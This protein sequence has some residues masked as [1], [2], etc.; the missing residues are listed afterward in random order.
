MAAA[1][2]GFIFV[3]N[4]VAFH[5]GALVLLGRY[6]SKLHRAYS[7]FYVIGTVGAMQIP[8]VG[9]RPLQSLEQIG[10]LVVFLAFQILEFVEDKRRREKL[11][12]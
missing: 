5:A 9:W 8:V 6:S 4:M 10:G 3:I 12:F 11:D 1:W 7:L 2:G